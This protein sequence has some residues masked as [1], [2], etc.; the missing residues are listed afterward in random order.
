MANNL[1]KILSAFAS[2][3]IEELSENLNNHYTYQDASKD[4]FINAVSGIFNRF[5][6]AGDTELLIYDGICKALWCR[7]KFKTGYRFI[8]DHTGNSLELIF[9][10]NDKGDDVV[11]I[12]QCNL[13]ETNS[14]SPQVGKPFYVCV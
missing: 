13:F 2:L 3:S 12:F 14:P 10:L 11:D 9:A 4:V 8:G 6:E 5:K 1:E 7:N